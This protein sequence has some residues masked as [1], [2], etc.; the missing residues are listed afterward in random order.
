MYSVVIVG[1]VIFFLT[2][3]YCNCDFSKWMMIS[4]KCFKGSLWSW[5]TVWII[6]F[7]LII[8][9]W[10]WMQ[11]HENSHNHRR[12]HLKYFLVLVPREEEKIEFPCL[13][14]SFSPHWFRSWL[15]YWVI[16]LYSLSVLSGCC[17]EHEFPLVP[18]DKMAAAD[19]IMVAF[20]ED[21]NTWLIFMLYSRN[22]RKLFHIL[23]IES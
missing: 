4:Q 21:N 12:L 15:V 7:F 16:S 9:V 23:C 2:Y 14:M 20:D 6:F 5:S 17:L 8:D 10:F 11:I 3:C 13:Y 18:W 22:R 1:V 19:R